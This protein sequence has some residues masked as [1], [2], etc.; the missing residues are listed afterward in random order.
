[1]T[2]L[3]SCIGALS[4]QSYPRS[5]LDIIVVETTGSACKHLQL[6]FPFIRFTR[7]DAPGLAAARN[8][9]AAIAAGDIV[10][11]VDSNCRPACD[12]IENGVAAVHNSSI[13]CVVTSNI[14]GRNVAADAPFASASGAAAAMLVPAAVWRKVGPFRGSID[15][16]THDEWEWA[17]RASK[18]GI[19]FVYAPQALVIGH[20]LGK[21]DVNELGQRKDQGGLSD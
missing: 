19:C 6:E 3:Y 13:P 10:A 5:Y 9:G 20:G 14:R 12:W 16:P 2:E 7:E 18:A 1:M 8:K 21:S 17:A 11:F 15:E 4:H